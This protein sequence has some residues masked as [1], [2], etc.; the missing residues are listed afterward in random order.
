MVIFGIFSRTMLNIMSYSL[1]Y[2][3]GKIFPQTLGSP[4]IWEYRYNI[5]LKYNDTGR[6]ITF[7]YGNS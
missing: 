5:S 1:V 4:T 2:E 6:G 7:P 3:V